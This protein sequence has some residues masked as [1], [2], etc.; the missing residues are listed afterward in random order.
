[1]RI[2]GH[3][4]YM[5]CIVRGV[6]LGYIYLYMYEILYALYSQDIFT[7]M[8]GTLGILSILKYLY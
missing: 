3:I 2:A 7:K 5:T 6:L 4:W 8:F 1:M